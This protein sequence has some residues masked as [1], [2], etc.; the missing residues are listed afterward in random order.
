MGEE[1]TE[2]YKKL[3][4]VVVPVFCE[5]KNIGTVLERIASSIEPRNIAYEIVVVDDGSHDGTWTTLSSCAE[6]LPIRAVRLSRNFGKELALCAGLER[7]R[8]DAVIVMDGDGQH[9]PEV[10]SEMLTIWLSGD[11]EIIDAVKKT[12]GKE[13]IL[14]K[15]GA[16]IFYWIWGRLSGFDLAAASDFKLLSR[17][18]VAAYL[19][20]GERNVFFR[21]MTAWLGFSRAKVYFEVAGREGGTST[22]SFFLLVNLALTGITGFSAVPLQII[23]VLGL[24]F[25]LFAL[26]FGAQ[27]LYMFLSGHAMTGFATVILLLLFIGSLLMFSLGIMGEYLGR[28]Y[29]EV[30]R[31]PR[32]VIAET[33]EG[34]ARDASSQK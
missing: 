6:K 15:L 5:E 3:V 25:M 22:W 2:D 13:S 23:T 31:R 33:I 9:P 14:S 1:R 7:A 34:M 17:Q 18:A 16:R 11:A 28:I 32:Y 27:T 26:V 24:V 8:G 10:I 20:M 30:K 4:S 19:Q 29:D 12:R 21:G